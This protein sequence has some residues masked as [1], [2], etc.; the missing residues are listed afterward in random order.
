VWGVF[1]IKWILKMKRKKNPNA[2]NPYLYEAIP[3]VFFTLGIFGTFVGIF[4]GLHDFD[5]SK[6]TESI[7]TLLEGMKTAFLTSIVGIVLS[8]IFGRWSQ[9]ILNKVEKESS[10]S[11]NN[12]LSALQEIIRLMKE[13]KTEA[14]QN[15]KTLNKSLIGETADS[16]SSQIVKLR[17]QL[18]ETQNLYA[19]QTEILNSVLSVL[20]SND[21][22]SLLIQIQELRAEQNNYSKET[23]KSFEWIVKSMNENNKL[24]SKKFDKFSELL[25]KNNTETLVNVM[26]KATEQ[27]N[28]QMSAL[29]EKLVK[30]NFEELNN[31]VQRMNQWQQENK[32]MITQLTV[33]FTKV[34]E[35]FAI[36]SNAIKEITTNTT[37]LTDKN[38]HLSRLIQELQK[39]MIEDTRY[40]EIMKK[41]TDTVNT[42][43]KIPIHLT[44]QQTN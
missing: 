28:A 6:I 27:F 32:K 29:V 21:E 38:S 18:T 36:S 2:V 44:K 31:S 7:P 5:V 41:L 23:K 19:E 33:Q 40:Q 24:I 26:K 30:E 8:F 42:L 13:S 1:S 14:D 35:D 25:A 4:Y 11:A 10:T 39:V 3:S 17:K 15:S 9:R 12:E 16:I 22:N 34:S 20:G 43:K 37:K